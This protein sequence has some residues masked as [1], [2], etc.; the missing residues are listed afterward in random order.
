MVDREALLGVYE[1]FAEA[2]LHAYE[3]GEVLY[4]LTDRVVAVLHVAGAGVWLADERGLTPVTAS[5]AT[6]SAIQDRQRAIDAGPCHDAHRHNRQVRI[7]DLRAGGPWP[8]AH[9]V[10]LARGMHAVAALPMPVG[11]RRIGA[12][13]LYRR[14]PAA[15]GEWEVRVGQV[16]ANMA[17]GYVLRNLELSESR[18]LADQLQTALDTRVVVEQAKGI[19]S[20]H[21]DISTDEAF[22]R[23]RARAGRDGLSLHEACRRVVRATEAA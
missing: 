18:T 5:D 22:T 7:A 11:D 3:I 6:A 9:E 8:R 20:A 17:S 13:A 2:L 4:A 21:W 19:L 14:E 10:A 23:L 1:S 15:W 12:M 16:L